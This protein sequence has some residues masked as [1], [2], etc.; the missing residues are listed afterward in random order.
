MSALYSEEDEITEAIG[1]FLA[2][3]L[4]KTFRNGLHWRER[5]NA[6]PLVT[7]GQRPVFLDGSGVLD[8]MMA[9]DF[10]PRKTVFLPGAA[11]EAVRISGSP[12]ARVNGVSVRAHEITCEVTTQEA[13]LVVIAQGHYPRWVCRVGGEETPIYRA[14]NAFQAV[15]VPAGTHAVRL[16]YEDVWFR[17]GTWVSLAAWFLAIPV[18]RSSPSISGRVGRSD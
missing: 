2:I 12:D 9:A 7:A 15:V 8:G 17:L 10:D 5:P 3:R 18:W 4:V 6:M 1:D 14:N 13:A 16:S 11:A